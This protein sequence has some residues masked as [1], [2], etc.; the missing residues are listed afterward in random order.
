MESCKSQ[1]YLTAHLSQVLEPRSDTIE[2][3]KH[4][5]PCISFWIVKSQISYRVGYLVNWGHSRHSEL[6]R[7]LGHL[8]QIQISVSKLRGKA[9]C[10]RS[11]SLGVDPRL[12]L[13]PP[14]SNLCCFVL[15][16]P[17]SPLQTR[18][19]KF[20]SQGQAGLTDA[21]VAMWGGEVSFAGKHYRKWWLNRMGLI[22]RKSSYS[23]LIH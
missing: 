9:P 6:K 18:N 22:R 11:Q 13:R 12:N 5:P 20:L 15:Y 4:L 3:N 17:L 14:T 23:D 19:S 16:L 2:F 8:A 10:L 1:H 21:C 7:K